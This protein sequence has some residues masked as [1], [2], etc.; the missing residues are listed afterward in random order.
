[1]GFLPMKLFKALKWNGEVIFV[2]EIN[3]TKAL[4][5]YR[6]SNKYGVYLCN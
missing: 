6:Q 3:P 2:H 4:R 5:V 1:M